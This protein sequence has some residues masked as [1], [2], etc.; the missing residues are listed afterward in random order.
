[1][2]ADHVQDLICHF[3][4]DPDADPD[5]YPDFYLMRIRIWMRIQ[6]TKMM[7]IHADLDPQH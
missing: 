4:A 7:R 5:P 1:M 2:D 6:D 3:N